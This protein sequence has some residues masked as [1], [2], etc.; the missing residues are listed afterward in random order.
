MQRFLPY[1]FA[2]II[3]AAPFSPVLAKKKPV[4]PVVNENPI[5]VAVETEGGGCNDGPPCDTITTLYESGVCDGIKCARQAIPADEITQFKAIIEKTD[6]D[7]IKQKRFTGDCPT[8]PYVPKFTYTFYTSNGKVV[9]EP[10][11]YDITEYRDPF[12]T[13]WKIL[14]KK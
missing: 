5:I 12:H 3:A 10:C 2:A 9:F 13:L 14:D 7:S 8:N 6:F 1:I 11:T 4:K